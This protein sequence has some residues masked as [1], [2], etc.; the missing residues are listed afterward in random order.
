[1]KLECVA[2]NFHLPMVELCPCV[3]C[4]TKAMVRIVELVFTKRVV[5]LGE[6]L[7]YRDV[8]SRGYS[9]ELCA[10]PQ[11]CQSVILTMVHRTASL[12]TRSLGFEPSEGV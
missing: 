10:V 5:Q 6:E 4:G 9:C 2:Q 11:H 8:S 3:L 1:M 7:N 12:L